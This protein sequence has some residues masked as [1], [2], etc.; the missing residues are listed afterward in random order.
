MPPVPPQTHPLTP[1][2]AAAPAP[3]VNVLGHR[4]AVHHPARDRFITP[5]L[6][7]AGCFEPF[8][9]ELVANE[10]RPGDTVLDLGA[11]IGYYTLFLARL[12]GSGGRVISVEPDPD[13]FALLSRNVR[14]NGY[15]HVD[16][17]PVAASN[18]PARCGLFRSADNAGDHRLYDS[19]GVTRPAVE[20]EAVPVDQ[21]FRTRVGGVNFVK[22]DVQ[23]F[24]VAALEGMGHRSRIALR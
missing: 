16:L 5:S 9:T 13:N 11:H 14:L 1:E 20:V 17:F 23:G 15:A 4:M 21:L 22:I 3:V 18:K 12:V 6:I 2:E 7:H 24:E 19:E 8:L 10:V